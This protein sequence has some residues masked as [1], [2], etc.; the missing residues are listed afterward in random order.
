MPDNWKYSQSGIGI[1]C[2]AWRKTGQ[3]KGGTGTG[4]GLL[5]QF[6][7]LPSVLPDQTPCSDYLLLAAELD[8]LP[9]NMPM[10]PATSRTPP[11]ARTAYALPWKLM[12]TRI[13][14]PAIR[15]TT[16]RARSA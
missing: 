5:F 1:A 14:T 12:A 9:M 16:P 8:D 3:Q 13:M 10:M 11:N 15:A 6:S 2:M 7:L 4:K